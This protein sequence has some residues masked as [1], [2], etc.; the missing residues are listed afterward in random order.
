MWVATIKQNDQE[1]FASHPHATRQA[2]LD[3]AEDYLLK[4]QL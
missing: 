3:E 1:L 2:A 4:G